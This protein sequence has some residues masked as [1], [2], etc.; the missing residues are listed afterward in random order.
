[1]TQPTKPIEPIIG[2]DQ[3]KRPFTEVE[4][5]YAEHLLRAHDYA[6]AR[7]TALKF[8]YSLTHNIDR[9]KEIVGRASLRLV[10]QGW[11]PNKVTLVRALCRFTWSEFTHL[12]EETAAAKAAAERYLKELEATD[13]L[14][15][16]SIEEYMDRLDEER[17]EEARAMARMAELR[18]AFVEAKDEVNLI[19]MQMSLDGIDDLLEMAKRSGRDVKEF[20]RATDRR[21]RHVRRLAG[22]P[23]GAEDQETE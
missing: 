20:Y 16:P 17:R 6:G 10:R 8:A 22:A 12:K 2:T 7:R 13:G 1:M 15:S 18:A 9:S 11:D 4:R 14:H 21:K 3:L 23:E 5:E 19:W